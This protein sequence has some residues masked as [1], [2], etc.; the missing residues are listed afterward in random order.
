M[1]LPMSDPTPAPGR[2][3][4]EALRITRALR[5]FTNETELY[6]GAAGR[7]AAM[8][9]TDLA[10]L[11]VV[12]DRGD[13]GQTTTPGQLSSTLQLSAPATS[14]MLDRLEQLGHVRRSPHPEDRRS[15]VVEITD[16]AREV[17]GAMFA[18]LAAHLAPVLGSRSENELAQIATFLEEAV[19]ATRSARLE[20]K[21]R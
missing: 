7:E 18:R 15:V 16:H 3:T 20:F 9:R 13:T 6:I 11:A 14:A 21:R 19:E 4:G 12:M 2:P 10:G 17:G 1:V 8:H 5:E